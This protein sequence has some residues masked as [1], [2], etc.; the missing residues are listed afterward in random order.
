LV[1]QLNITHKGLY[2]KI[3]SEQLPDLENSDMTAQTPT[4]EPK[5]KKTSRRVSTK[6]QNKRWWAKTIGLPIILILLGAGGVITTGINAYITYLSEHKANSP[7]SSQPQIILIQEDYYHIG[8][9]EYT[10]VVQNGQVVDKIYFSHPAPQTNP[11]SKDFFVSTIPQI[12]NLHLT[13][14]SIDPNEKNSAVKIFINGSFIDYLNRYFTI[15][16]MNE[17]SVSIPISVDMLRNG[18]NAIQIHVE[19][20]AVNGQINLDDIEFRN[21]YLEIIP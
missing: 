4:Q 5:Q 8:D 10:A 14:K 12:A 2:E 9:V 3:A 19:S 11:F 17:Q 20:G 15:E 18:K 1:A 21:I 13:A 16:T 7:A 6:E